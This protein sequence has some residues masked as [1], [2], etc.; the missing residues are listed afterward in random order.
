MSSLPNTSY[1]QSKKAE[2]QEFLEY[3]YA[4]KYCNPNLKFDEK[5]VYNQLKNRNL[6][7]SEKNEYG[8]GIDVRRFF[9]RWEENFKNKNVNAFC[10]EVNWKYWF[11]FVN[12]LGYQDEFIKLYIPINMPHL[13]EGVNELFDFIA[14]EGIIH[15]SKV[16]S[17]T[18]ID[19]VI[20]RL[21]KG[22]WESA[23]KIIDFINNNKYLKTGLNK[24]NPFV[25]S[26]NGIGIMEEHG[27]SYNTDISQFIARY[28]RKKHAMGEKVNID[29][30]REFLKSNCYDE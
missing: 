11:Q 13:Y 7:D 17:F 25:P 2:M 23:F 14:N 10:D 21:R 12:K 30:F 3:M 19:N 18:R 29:E 27:N 26:I 20:V 24:N 28:I 8:E 1:D 16:A 15:Q 9:S 4:I 5:I 6:P 22:D